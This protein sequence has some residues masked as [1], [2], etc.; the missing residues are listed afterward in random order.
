[1]HSNVAPASDEKTTS[2]EVLLVGDAGEESIAVS[3]AVISTVTAT[4]L[5]AALRLPTASWALAVRLF[6]PAGSVEAVRL[7]EPPPF[8]VVVATSVVPAR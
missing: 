5:E 6:D 3:G 1:M 2:A 4:A 7:Q 8:A